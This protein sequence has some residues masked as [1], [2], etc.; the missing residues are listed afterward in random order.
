MQSRYFAISFQLP[1]MKWCTKTSCTSTKFRCEGD[2]THKDQQELAPYFEDWKEGK[3]L[4]MSTQKSCLAKTAEFGT[5]NSIN[6]PAR[7]PS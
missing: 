7:G 6:L 5:K 4:G 1:K 3:Y 2:T